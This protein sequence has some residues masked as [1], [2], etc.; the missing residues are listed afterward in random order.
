MASVLSRTSDSGLSFMPDRA[1]GRN[2]NA[3]LR[4]TRTGDRTGGLTHTP[5]IPTGSWGMELER[6]TLNALSR[7]VLAVAAALPWLLVAPAADAAGT[8]GLAG[9]RG[10]RTGGAPG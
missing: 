7:L 2:I 3:A 10:Q 6:R 4:G 5:R 9:A 8:A 1:G